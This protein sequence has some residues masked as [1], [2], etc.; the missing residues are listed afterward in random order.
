MSVT[1]PLTIRGS[2]GEAGRARKD[3]VILN[4]MVKFVLGR[5]SKKVGP[6]MRRIRKSREDSVGL[7]YARLYSL[8]NFPPWNTLDNK[9]YG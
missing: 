3:A 8:L 1:V 6:R 7:Y 4:L 9:K 5:F 2:R